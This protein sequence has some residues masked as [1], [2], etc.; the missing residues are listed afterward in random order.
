ILDL[1]YTGLS[2]QA[3]AAAQPQLSPILPAFDPSLPNGAPGPAITTSMETLRQPLDIALGSGGTLTVTGTIMP[4]SA[5]R[6]AAEIGQYGE[7]VKTITL[8]SPGG[9]VTDAL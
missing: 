6:F 4:G 7:Y 5:E 1:D 9:S 2:A 3:P 8:N